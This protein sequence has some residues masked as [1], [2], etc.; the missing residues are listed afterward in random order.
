MHDIY[1]FWPDCGGTK[2]MSLLSSCSTIFKD[3]CL[4]ARE[5]FKGTVHEFLFENFAVDSAES[6]DT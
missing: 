3:L 2:F 1:D 4:Y 5:I 6:A